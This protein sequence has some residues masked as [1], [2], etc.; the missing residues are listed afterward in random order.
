VGGTRGEED[1]VFRQEAIRVLVG[2]VA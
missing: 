1:C 2:Q